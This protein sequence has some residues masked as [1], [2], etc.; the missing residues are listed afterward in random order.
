[1]PLNPSHRL[2]ICVPVMTPVSCP[3]SHYVQRGEMC[4]WFERL[5]IYFKIYKSWNRKN[6]ALVNLLWSV[7][8]Q[9][10]S[11]KWGLFMLFSVLFTWFVSRICMQL[12]RKSIEIEDQTA[13]FWWRKAMLLKNDNRRE[14]V[15]SY[16]IIRYEKRSKFA[17]FQS[18][19][20]LVANTQVLRRL[21]KIFRW[22]LVAAHC[23]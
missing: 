11:K 10:S 6:M 20:L 8:R 7:E 9:E 5:L 15:T 18:V 3:K 12:H 2:A 4:L 22:L 17:F 14:S 13:C 1:M 19:L 23:L 16:M 21:V